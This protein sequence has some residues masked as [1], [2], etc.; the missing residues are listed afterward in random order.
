MTDTS[1]S[2]TQKLEDDVWEAIKASDVY[3]ADLHAV[4][5]RLSK[6]KEK[7]QS[8]LDT[9]EA[10]KTHR[11]NFRHS[12]YIE[13]LRELDKILEGETLQNIGESPT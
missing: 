12:S 1:I 13:W 11:E 4:K 5:E 7:A 6:I 8:E 2:L 9:H 10:I 3:N